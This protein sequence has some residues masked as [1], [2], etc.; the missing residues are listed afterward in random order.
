MGVVIGLPTWPQSAVFST[1]YLRQVIA[2]FELYKWRESTGRTN[3]GCGSRTISRWRWRDHRQR[4][5]SSNRQP[6]IQQAV[7][8][9]DREREREREG[10]VVVVV[11]INTVSTPSL[12]LSLSLCQGNNGC[13]FVVVV[14][15]SIGSYPFQRGH[16]NAHDVF[17]FFCPRRHHPDYYY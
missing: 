6:C 3:K 13:T 9:T 7:A 11:L 15:A 10:S 2:K 16:N 5:Y 12:S 4:W 8:L 17:F 1:P 14:A